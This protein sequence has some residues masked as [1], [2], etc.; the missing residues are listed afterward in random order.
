VRSVLQ[1]WLPNAALKD[2]EAWA[3][4]ATKLDPYDYAPLWDCAFVYLNTGRFRKAIETY[5]K[6]H[7]LYN[8]GTDRLDRKPG[9]L[10]EMA[11]AYVHAGE[12]KKGIALLERAMRFPDWYQWNMG[13]AL[14]VAKDYEKA[15]AALQ[16]IDLRPSNPQYVPEVRLFLAASHHRH[17]EA[18]KKQGKTKEA[19]A[20]AR[21]AK[22]AV[23]AFRK[24]HPDYTKED[25][26]ATRSRFKNPQDEQHW[27]KALEDLGL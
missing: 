5:E 26:A 19:A 3:K 12:P 17:G 4:K 24:D 14:Y 21:K 20:Q 16:N 25:G 10:V 22:A 7:K 8:D 11:E 13:W 15:L 2:A 18:L 27:V 1:G 9:L 6:A 23:A